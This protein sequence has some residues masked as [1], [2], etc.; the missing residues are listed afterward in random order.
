M[1]DFRERGLIRDP[2]FPLDLDR[3]IDGF[4]EIEPRR[5][6]AHVR[7]KHILIVHGDADE[8]IP[9]DHGREIFNHAPAGVAELHVI[10]GGVHRLRLDSRCIGMLKGV[11]PKDTRMESLIRRR[12]R[13][14]AGIA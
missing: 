3:W 12:P 13:V 14:C 8:L 9:V 4:K 11:V 10:P 7:A 6:I 5:W 2:R 1:A